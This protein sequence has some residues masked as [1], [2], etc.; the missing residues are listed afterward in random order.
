MLPVVPGQHPPLPNPAETPRTSCDERL[1]ARNY[2]I[3]PVR[4]AEH[5]HIVNTLVRRRFAWRGYSTEALAHHADEAN[6]LTLAA[7]QHGELVATLTL[8][9]DSAEG[10]QADALYASELSR[11]R[12]TGR[13]LCEVSRLAVDPGHSCPRLLRALFAAALEYG[14]QRFAASD[15]VIGVN[16]RHAAY[17]QRRMG[18]RQ[19]GA[20]RHYARVGAPVV[21]LHQTL[22]GMLASAALTP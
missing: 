4:T 6:R 15:V 10:F 20:Q 21:L 16:P 19:I 1:R 14:S 12:R 11:L 2:Q 3:A 22:T 18:F 5:Q 17:Y 9:R 8:A 13:R 7:W